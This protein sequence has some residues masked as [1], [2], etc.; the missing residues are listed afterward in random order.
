MKNLKL[1]T[2]KKCQTEILEPDLPSFSVHWESCTLYTDAIKVMSTKKLIYFLYRLSKWDTRV[3]LEKK[4]EDDNNGRATISYEG[5]R[6][7]LNASH[8]YKYSYRKKEG[9]QQKS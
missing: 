7:T 4:V 3:I 2:H 8:E 6:K 5:G 1:L 9:K